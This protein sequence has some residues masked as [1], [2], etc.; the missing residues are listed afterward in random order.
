MSGPPPMP[1]N[2]LEGGSSASQQTGKLPSRKN[3]QRGRG[4]AGMRWNL[5]SRRHEAVS[6]ANRSH[7]SSGVKPDMLLLR[8]VGK[9]RE[10]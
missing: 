7:L 10:R 2:R 6:A 4:L 9:R 1:I 8:L 3:L 5:S